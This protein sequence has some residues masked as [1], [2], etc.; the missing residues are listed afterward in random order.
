MTVKSGKSEK[1]LIW[2]HG[3][4]KTPPWSVE[5]RRE[6]GF[7]LRRLQLGD[8]LSLPVSRPMQTHVCLLKSDLRWKAKTMRSLS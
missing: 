1:P 5:A 4:V 6:A 8:L 2:L 7:L 3:E